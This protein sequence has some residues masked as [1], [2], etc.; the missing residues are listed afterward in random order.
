[1]GMV[2]GFERKKPKASQPADSTAERPKAPSEQPRYKQVHGGIVVNVHVMSPSGGSNCHSAWLETE[3]AIQYART[4]DVLCT[5]F[6]MQTDPRRIPDEELETG[7][8]GRLFK[9]PKSVIDQIHRRLVPTAIPNAANVKSCSGGAPAT[10]RATPP[11]C[12]E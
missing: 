7:Q 2:D 5:K 9:V 4:D 6:R 8:T 11:L 3:N 10:A 1:M 12:L